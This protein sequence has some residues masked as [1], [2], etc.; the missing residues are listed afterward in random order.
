MSKLGIE[1]LNYGDRLEVALANGRRRSLHANTLWIES[2]SAAGRRRR[3]DGTHTMV[4]QGLRIT[5]VTEVGAYG[6]HVAF[7]ADVRGGVFPWPMLIE[8]SERLQVADF[9]APAA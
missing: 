8:L 3:I 7:S 6:L 2:P 4:P 9:I 5:E 1:V